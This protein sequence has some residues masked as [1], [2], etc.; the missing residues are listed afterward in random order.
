MLIATE[1]ECDAACAKLRSLGT[2]GLD[3]ENVAYIPPHV[4]VSREAAALAQ[5]C[6]SD[7]ECF[8]FLLHRWPQAYPSFVALITDPLTKKVALNVAHDASSLRKRFP[9]AVLQGGL[10]LRETVRHLGLRAHKLEE[11]AGRVARQVD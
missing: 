4:G 11:R 10:E 7:D 9:T 8:L 6:G 2:F 5:A 3:T 1:A